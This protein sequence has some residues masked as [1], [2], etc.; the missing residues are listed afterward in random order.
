MEFGR[1]WL[2]TL[3]RWFGD[4]PPA[5]TG[6]A[7]PPEPTPGAAPPVVVAG[8]PSSASP[9]AVAAPAAIDRV[10][11]PPDV[12]PE[13]LPNEAL[14]AFVASVRQ[15][16]LFSATALRLMRSVE[17]ADVTTSELDRLISTDAGLVAGLLRIVNSPYYGVA[18]RVSTVGDAIAILGFD[19]VR[20]TISAAVTQRPLMSYLHDSDRVRV[21]WRHEL[22]C[23]AIARHLAQ[24]AGLDG[25][26][27]Y[28]AG[29]M[30][31]VG[32]LAMLIAHPHLRERLL[33]VQGDIDHR[34]IEREYAEFGFDHAQVGGALLAR[35][36][37]PAAIVRAAEEHGGAT[38]PRD[39]LS[40]TVWRA[41]LMS[42]ALAMEADELDGETPWMI[43]AGIDLDGRRRLLDEIAALESAQG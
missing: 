25:E 35:W 40:A 16:P 38:A 21:F 11:A 6:D 28:M 36:G 18:R 39:P 9:P 27:A 37:L 42:H 14:D 41:N 30:H 4:A 1:R 19:Q 33:R 10:A 12:L 32:R 17:R 23:A 7:G 13:Q 20:R 15:L 3:A 8:P 31:E 26:V 2:A 43:D 29:L 34:G 22:T 5:A 24:G